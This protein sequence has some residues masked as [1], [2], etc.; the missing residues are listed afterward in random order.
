MEAVLSQR[1]YS[2]VKKGLYHT[3]LHKGRLLLVLSKEL[4]H[5]ADGITI[6]TDKK[7]YKDNLL[8]FNED[9]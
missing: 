3:I 2:S 5:S 9:F 4:P 6:S 7:K 1:A 8:I